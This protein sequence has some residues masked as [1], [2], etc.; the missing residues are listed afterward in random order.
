MTSGKKEASREWKIF[1][2]GIPNVA[3][4]YSTFSSLPTVAKIYFKVSIEATQNGTLPYLSPNHFAQIDGSNSY[5]STSG[6]DQ[7]TLTFLHIRHVNERVD[8]SAV[9][10]R[11]GSCVLEAQGV[12]NSHT[13]I[14]RSNLSCGEAGT[15]HSHVSVSS[16][17]MFDFRTNRTDDP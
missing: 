3:V 14:C 1:F 12:R 2:L 15:I 9:N 8:D 6:M 16:L 13:T 4:K 11:H 7:N 17:E 10:T 5:P